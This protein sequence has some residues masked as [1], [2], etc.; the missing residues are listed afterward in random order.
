[1][2]DIWG[3]RTSSTC[4][5]YELVELGFKARSVHLLSPL[6]INQSP[7]INNKTYRDMSAAFRGRKCKSM[8]VGVHICVPAYTYRLR[9]AQRASKTWCYHD[10]QLTQCYLPRILSFSL[11][12]QQ[13][14]INTLFPFSL[15]FYLF[16]TFCW[17]YLLCSSR[18]MSQQAHC[19]VTS[20][21]VNKNSTLKWKSSGDGEDK[22]VMERQHRK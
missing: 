20:G 12:I 1:M 6:I 7:I 19:L 10:T 18:W 8:C 21:T 15:T 9:C 11:L 13:C 14:L 4:Y 2:S 16:P 3:A 22:E 17:K 5:S